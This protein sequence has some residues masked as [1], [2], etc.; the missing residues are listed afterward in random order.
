[1]VWN[2]DTSLVDAWIGGLDNET[3]ALILSTL[4]VLEYEGPS[5]GRPLV[6]RIRGS[7]YHNMKE[8]RPGSIGRTEIRILFVFDPYQQAILLVGGDKTKLWN[9]WYRK[10]IPLADKLYTQHLESKKGSEHGH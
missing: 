6:D 4:I 5:L 2:I 10:N 1:M 3:K 8:L 7:R 9:K